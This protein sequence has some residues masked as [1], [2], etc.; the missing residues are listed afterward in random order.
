M[1]GPQ[2]IDY[3]DSSLEHNYG[4]DDTGDGPFGNGL[5]DDARRQDRD[6]LQRSA[7]RMGLV[8]DEEDEASLVA[9]GHEHPMHLARFKMVDE[10]G[11]AKSNVVS[12]ICF[13][14]KN[15]R[16]ITQKEVMHL[17]TQKWRLQPANMLINCDAG[18]VHPKS[19]GT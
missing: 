12:E 7:S 4:V 8:D 15:S 6:T 3:D 11:V 1:K 18:S 16:P 19:L 9:G 10:L 14:Q 13:I 5:V 2:A 17:I